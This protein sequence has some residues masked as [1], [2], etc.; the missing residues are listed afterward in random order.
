[1][2]ADAN[3]AFCVRVNVIRCSDSSDAPNI[4]H[5]GFLYQRRGPR[6]YLGIDM[7]QPSYESLPI[8]RLPSLSFA[9]VLECDT[10]CEL[11]SVAWAL[12]CCSCHGSAPSIGLILESPPRPVVPESSGRWPCESL[13]TSG[14]Q[15]SLVL[16]AY[17]I[18]SPAWAGHQALRG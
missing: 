4:A 12:R 17:S 13:C 2:K 7:A 16:A 15:I 11:V 5:A 8:R 18:R 10:Q 1:M 3:D 6:S 14:I 9:P